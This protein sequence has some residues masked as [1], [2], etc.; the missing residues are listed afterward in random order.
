MEG[1]NGRASPCDVKGINE[2]FTDLSLS[3]CYIVHVDCTIESMHHVDV[4]CVSDVSEV[5]RP[6]KTSVKTPYGFLRSNTK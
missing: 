3:P 4:G 6:G 2:S 5:H 1:Y